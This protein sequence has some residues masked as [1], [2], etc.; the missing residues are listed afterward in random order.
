MD[1]DWRA[2]P[3]RPRPFLPLIL[4]AVILSTGCAA[5]H[6]EWEVWRA[7]PTHYATGNHLSFSM[8]NMVGAAPQVTPELMDQAKGEGWWGRNTPLVAPRANVPGKGEGTWSGYGMPRTVGGVVAKAR[9]TTQ[10]GI[11]QAPRARIC[12]R[13]PQGEPRWLR[14]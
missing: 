14:G 9:L 13:Q 8:K 3:M 12:A 10:R 6:R 7:H 1:F 2:S 4:G 5:T 11:G